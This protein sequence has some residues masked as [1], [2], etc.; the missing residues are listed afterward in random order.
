MCVKGLALGATLGA[1]HY[2]CSGIAPATLWSGAEK[3]LGAAERWQAKEDCF[4]ILPQLQYQFA[5]FGECPRTGSS[6]RRTAPGLNYL[7]SGWKKFFDI[8][9]RQKIV[10]SLGVPVIK[11][12]TPGRSLVGKDD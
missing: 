7:C 1:R 5:C 2:V 8:T 10:R 6:R 12:R 3:A 4:P 11:A 9:N